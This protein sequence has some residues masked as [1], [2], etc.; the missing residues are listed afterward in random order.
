MELFRFQTEL[1]ATTF[2]MNVSMRKEY[3]ITK[4]ELEKLRALMPM[5]I[6]LYEYAKQLHEYR[7]QNI[8]KTGIMFQTT[9]Q[10]YPKP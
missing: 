2:E 8:S 10:G 6:Y 9:D 1:N 7:W 3:N 5:D 4:V